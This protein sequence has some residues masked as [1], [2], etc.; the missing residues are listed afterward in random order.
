MRW[1]L[2]ILYATIV[3]TACTGTIDN[4][5]SLAS[6]ASY[7]SRVDDACGELAT[8]CQTS[9]RCD[10]Q[11]AFCGDSRA[12]REACRSTERA[13]KA[14]CN[15]D[16]SCKKDCKLSRRVCEST[17]GDNMCPALENTCTTSN[18][19]CVAA[20]F[21]CYDDREIPRACKEEEKACKA[22][23]SAGD[24]NCKHACKAARNA[25]A[26][27]TPPPEPPPDPMTPPDAGTPEPDAGAPEP[28]AGTP[29]PPPPPPPPRY[30][31]SADIAP[32]TSGFCSG[33][34]AA[35]NPDGNYLTDSLA[36]LFGNGTDAVPN[37]VA[38]NASS[39]FVLYMA[40]APGKNHKN[41]NLIYPG[42]GQIA[43]DWVV[44]DGA[45]P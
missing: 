33:C 25:C 2:S 11:A 6:H 31:Y 4:G 28:D 44:L 30:T 7:A 41:V 15:D 20:E 23:C 39:L 9:G 26:A 21:F 16:R 37:I 38:G 27:G 10:L 22:M 19:A 32:V 36:G 18:E 43:R 40:P 8:M 13:C 5:D 42:F 24:R 12:A 3:M 1:T 35:P 14:A 45:A 34:H 29:P 17:I